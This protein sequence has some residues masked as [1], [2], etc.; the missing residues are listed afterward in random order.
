MLLHSV[1]KHQSSKGQFNSRSVQLFDI[2]FL[3]IV[4]PAK[5]AHWAKDAVY[6]GSVTPPPPKCFWVLTI[7]QKLKSRDP[8]FLSPKL[9]LFI[10]FL[11]PGQKC[12]N[13]KS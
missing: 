5:R 13:K 10:Q 9:P 4:A 3:F 1:L 6:S 11:S 12:H 8:T 2:L 7:A